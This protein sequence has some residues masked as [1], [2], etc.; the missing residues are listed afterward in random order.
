MDNFLKDLLRH[1]K[2]QNKERNVSRSIPL[3]VKWSEEVRR[4]SEEKNK[5]SSM[6]EELEADRKKLWAIIELDLN[7]FKTDKRI[8]RE[9]GELEILE[10][11]GDDDEKGIPSP[12]TIHALGDE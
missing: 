5:I 9:K 4:M 10:D 6:M 12:Y 11:E 8:N 7:D 2:G 1:L 3:K